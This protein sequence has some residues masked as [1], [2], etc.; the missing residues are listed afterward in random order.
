MSLKNSFPGDP[1]NHNRFPYIAVAVAIT[2]LALAVCTAQPNSQAN[3]TSLQAQAGDGPRSTSPSSLPAGEERWIEVDL[4]QQ[5]VQLHDG[6]R[7]VGKYPAS[8]GRGDS[9]ST[10]T[11]TGTFQVYSKTKPLTYLSEYDVY[12]SD[13]VGFDQE[14]AIGFHSLPVDKQGRVVDSR[15]GMPVSHGCVR[16]GNAAA[17]FSFATIGMKVI[18]H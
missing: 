9:P 12:V 18:I 16:V 6:Q 17:I 11:Y 7:T 14:H 8:T 13:W 4:D 15:L 2:A 10:L 1:I 3:G 5:V